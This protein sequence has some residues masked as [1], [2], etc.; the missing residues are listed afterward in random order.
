M[1]EPHSEGGNFLSFEQY[2]LT[3]H[4]NNVESE[5]LS[6]KYRKTLQVDIWL[7]LPPAMPEVFFSLRSNRTTV[8][9]LLN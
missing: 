5:L 6:D 8:L 4:G 7:T 1:D 2:D 9:V 3:L